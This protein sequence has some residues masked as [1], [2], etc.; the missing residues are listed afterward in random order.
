MIFIPAGHPLRYATD[1]S[2]VTAWFT[3]AS[4]NESSTSL[5]VCTL[6]R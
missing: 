1:L 3:G 4:T 6:G 2:D 5:G